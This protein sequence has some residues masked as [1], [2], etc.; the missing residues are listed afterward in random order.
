MPFP[1]SRRAVAF[2]LPALALSGCV[3]GG[4]A[5]LV[6]RDEWRSV[7]NAEF[8]RWLAGFRVRAVEG[9]PLVSSL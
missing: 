1:I 2:G 9:G 8:D 7:P 6:T 3:T 5:A 4:G